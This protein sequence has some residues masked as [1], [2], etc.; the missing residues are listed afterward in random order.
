[1]KKIILLLLSFFIME[2]VRAYDLIESFY[3]NDE[4]VENMWITKV[5]GDVIAS[6][7]PFILK[8]VSD[9]AYVYC[10]QPFVLLKTEENY[11]GYYDIVDK[12]SLTEKQ[13]ERIRLLS[14]FGYQ[15]L[16]HTDIKWYGITQYLIW[17]TI[18]EEADIYFTDTRYGNRIEIYQSEIAEI[19]NLIDEYLELLVYNN[20]KMIFT[21]LE[22]FSKWKDSNIFLKDINISSNQNIEI[23]I[24]STNKKEIFFYHESGQN[25]YLQRSLS[26]SN[27]SL[28][29]EFVKEIIIRKWYGSGK[30]DFEEGATFEIYKDNKLVDTIVT[31]KYGIAHIILP[32]GNYNIIQTSGIEGYKFVDPFEINIGINRLNEVIELYDEAEVIEVPDTSKNIPSLLLIMPLI[33]FFIKVLR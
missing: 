20:Q 15:Y 11:H 29:I 14:H 6:G 10:L 3:Y 18:D 31:D 24:N 25:V 26:I 22:E 19:E 8:R 7:V 23:S 16:N 5:K 33:F 1:M 2:N 4:K 9:N 30:Y 12:F 32:Y 17:K 13:I 27:I 28:E 21:D